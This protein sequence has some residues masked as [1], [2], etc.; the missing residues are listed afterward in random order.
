M[1]YIVMQCSDQIFGVK[2]SEKGGQGLLLTLWSIFSGN[3]LQQKI[4]MVSPLRTPQCWTPAH[5]I[6]P[7]LLHTGIVTTV[8]VGFMHAVLLAPGITIQ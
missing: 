6:L 5:R 2:H 7:A 8:P 4:K 3:N 1:L